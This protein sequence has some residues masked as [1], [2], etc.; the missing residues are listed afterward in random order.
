MASSRSTSPISSLSTP[1]AQT[2]HDLLLGVFVEKGACTVGRASNVGTG[3][4]GWRHTR[5]NYKKSTRYPSR[6]V[7]AKMQG[8]LQTCRNLRQIGKQ[9]QVRT[10]YTTTTPHAPC[11]AP[12]HVYCN[13]PHDMAVCS[14]RTCELPLQTLPGTWYSFNRTGVCVLSYHMIRQY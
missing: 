7:R 5:D 3:S 14:R 10:R 9:D 12:H 8:S 6:G 4:G 13:A 11:L 2:R 1:A